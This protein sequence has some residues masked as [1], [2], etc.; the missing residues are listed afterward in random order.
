MP[1][2]T[3]ATTV[4][5]P[6]FVK[7]GGLSR[8]TLTMPFSLGSFGLNGMHQRLAQLFDETGRSAHPLQRIGSAA[9]SAMPNSN[10]GATQG[11]GGATAAKPIMSADLAFPPFL[12]PSISA[13]ANG[14]I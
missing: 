12:Q 1:S 3:A 6:I 2:S 8:A 14:R 11:V 13:G 5:N 9:P 10:G 7:N 4:A